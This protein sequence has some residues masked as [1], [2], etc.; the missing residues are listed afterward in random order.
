MANIATLDRYWQTVRWL[1]PVQIYGRLWFRLSRPRFDAR[2]P[3]ALRAP[4]GAWVAPAR[5]RASLTGPRIFVFLNQRGD[6]SECGWDDPGRDKLWRYNQHYF[7]DLNS[8][9]ALERRD[10]HVAL[11]E[12]WLAQNPPG[13][14]TGW[15]PYPTSLRIVNWIK[16]SL[17]GNDL[18]DASRYSLAIQ[19]RWLTRR[20]ERHLLGNHLFANAKALVFAGLF[21][22]G[23][24]AQ[25]WLDTGLRILAHEVPEQILPDGGQFELS[26]M[27]HAL[28]LED[29]LDLSNITQAYSDALAQNQKCAS[30]EW[31]ARVPAMRRWLAGMTHPDGAIA[32]FNDATFGVAPENAE[33]EAYAKRLDLAPPIDLDQQ[34]W[35]SDSG[36]IRFNHPKASLI[37]D[38]G[39]VGPDYLPGHAHADTL[40]FELSVFGQRIFVNSGTSLYGTSAERLRQRGTAA[41]NTV[42]VAGENSSDVWSGFRVGRRASP[43]D[44]RV[45]REGGLLVAEATHDGY[46][47]LPGRPLHHRSWRFSSE[48]LRVDDAI[49][50]SGLAAEA[51]F[52]LHPEV[53]ITQSALNAGTF[54]LPS[55]ETIHWRSEGGSVRVDPATWHPEFGASLET[56]CL[57]VP[58]HDG[59]AAL[60]VSWH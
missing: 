48:A 12:D 36:Y 57:V 52:H 47:R 56:T 59:C 2:P 26:P 19:T 16:W 30:E 33:I 34:T 49:Q 41:H 20:L 24:E 14:G 43:I 60:T 51:R 10:W 32:F 45:S 31:T 29:V 28:A 22:D 46:Q 58:L 38:M 1:R 17:A 55:G 7:D 5:R 44:P 23:P 53:Q 13:V 25:V 40:S 18:N 15:E 37:A 11:L 4:S 3:P 54:I 9:D 6:L 35:F 21:F 8:L 39:H 42:T 27:Y 50:A